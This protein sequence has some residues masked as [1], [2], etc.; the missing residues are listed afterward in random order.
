M[1]TL[2]AR[3]PDTIVAAVQANVNWKNQKPYPGA[4]SFSRLV[5]RK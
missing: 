1:F 5:P 3:D 4:S 2:S